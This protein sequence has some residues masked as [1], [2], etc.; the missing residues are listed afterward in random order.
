[1][2]IHGKRRHLEP[3]V[4]ERLAL[5]LGDRKLS[6]GTRFSN[7]VATIVA[8]DLAAQ[9]KKLVMNPEELAGKYSDDDIRAIAAELEACLINKDYPAFQMPSEKWITPVRMAT[10]IYFERDA[11]FPCVGQEGLHLH[12]EIKRGGHNPN[13]EKLQ[14]AVFERMQTLPPMDVPKP[15]LADIK[16]IQDTEKWRDTLIVPMRGGPGKLFGYELKIEPV[17]YLLDNSIDFIL[18]E[19]MQKAR[20]QWDNREEVDQQYEIIAD[21]MKGLQA[22]I[23]KEEVTFSFDGLRIH[24]TGITKQIIPMFTVLGNGLRPEQWSDYNWAYGKVAHD[25]KSIMNQY[26]LQRRRAKI[27]MKAKAENGRG[28]IDSITL[29]ALRA[30]NED[31]AEMLK[32]LSIKQRIVTKIEMKSGKNTAL[33]LSWRNGV[34]MGSFSFDK[35]TAW[36][37][38]SF[39]LKN[40]ALPASVISSL[41]GRRLN[42]L[43]EHP[44]IDPSVDIRSVTGQN[45]GWLKINARIKTF[46]FN[47]ETGEILGEEES[48]A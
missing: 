5:L 31:V 20:E 27:L 47:P 33:N 21:Y 43:V 4:R 7:A 44:F 13:V 39:V 2:N 24:F 41:I 26:A 12:R 46:V 30:S 6:N 38:G 32:K 36:N 34:V 1:M 48:D 14:Q 17:P 35:N 18:S 16:I 37:Y 25:F 29:A 19:I 22:K 28:R 9:P 10:G 8:H 45:G 11:F 15:E 23:Q 40:R 42:E 3:A